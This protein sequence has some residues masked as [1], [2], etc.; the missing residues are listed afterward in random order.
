[1]SKKIYVITGPRASGKTSAIVTLPTV[2]EIDKLI[3]IDTE[4]SAERAYR[5]VEKATKGEKNFTWIRAYERFKLDDDMLSRIADGKL[6]WVSKQQKSNLISY[7]EWFI[8]EL[9]T[10]MAKDQYLYL[11]IDTIEPIEAAMTAWVENNKQASGWSGKRAHGGL[12]VEGV[13]PLYENLLE[14]IGRRGIETIILTTHLKR[15]WENNAPI[16]NKVQPGGRLATL[17]RLSTRMFW[18]FPNQ[19][20]PKGAPSAV[21][22][23]ARDMVLTVDQ[24]TRRLVPQRALPPRI[25][26]FNWQNVEAYLD[27]PA[28]FANLRDDEKLTPEEQQVISEMLTD[29]QVRL[30]VIGSEKELLAMQQEQVPVAISGMFDQTDAVVSLIIDGLSD[31]EIMAEIPGV[32]RATLI[33]AHKQA[34][35]LAQVE[36]DAN[37]D[38]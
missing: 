18:L 31:D 24:E 21:V 1:M 27:N 3:L 30:M 34:A 11:G 36:G 4:D 8:A 22:L 14:A 13:R 9:D 32:G 10:R 20:N 17:S 28:D 19:T 38:E 26:V 37:D 33:R 23:K 12:E 16:L 5:A 7:Y 25:P 6:P 29:E 35:Q 2:D 15:V